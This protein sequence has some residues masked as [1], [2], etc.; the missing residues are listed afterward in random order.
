LA[1]ARYSYSEPETIVVPSG[2]GYIPAQ[3]WSIIHQVDV[4]AIA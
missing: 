1:K 4:K 3:T 2:S